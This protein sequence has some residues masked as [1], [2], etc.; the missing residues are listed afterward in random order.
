MVAIYYCTQCGN[1]ASA[2]KRG[3]DFAPLVGI[4]AACIIAPPWKWGGIKG[5]GRILLTI[6]IWLFGGLVS[7]ALWWMRSYTKRN[8]KV[9]L[10]RWVNTHGDNCSQWPT[11]GRDWVKKHGDDPA[12][13]P[14]TELQQAMRRMM[15]S[16]CDDD[17][18]D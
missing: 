17:D 15:G 8:Y 5:D 14:P 3:H 13:W 10:N 11:P 12:K 18:S 9:I 2:Y 6:G 7:F 4:L 16:D 1:S